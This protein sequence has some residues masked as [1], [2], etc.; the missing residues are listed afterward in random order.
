MRET[1]QHRRNQE[2]RFVVSLPMRTEILQKIEDSKTIAIK[3]FNN[4]EKKFQRRP[5]LRVEYE[6]FM[7]E[8]LQL[9]YIREI[10]EDDAT[11]N[12]QPQYYMSHHCII[13]ES[14]KMTKLRVVFNASSKRNAGIS[15]NDA[16]MVGPVLQQDLF[17]IL[18]RF[19]S[20]K[21]AMTVDIVKMYRQILVEEEQTPLQRIVWRDKPTEKLKTYELLTLTYGTASYSATKVIQH[22]STLEENQFPIGAKIARRDF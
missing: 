4:L 8:Y 14:N 17:S 3:Y 21:Y 20:F 10:K 19:Q 2:G 22:L 1:L 18:L 5:Q 12:V 11:W 16:L 13:K 7:R 9:Q 6:R 15:L